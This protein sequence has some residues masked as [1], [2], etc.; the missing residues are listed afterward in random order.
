MRPFRC[1]KSAK[2]FPSPQKRTR[3]RSGASTTQFFYCAEYSQDKTRIGRKILGSLWRT[4]QP[5]VHHKGT[6][7]AYYYLRLS[8]GQE[9][10]L[11]FTHNFYPRLEQPCH[12]V[13]GK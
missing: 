12:A 6:S 9:A 11:P 7:T 8:M 1:Q 2:K 3:E 4:Q 10:F 13:P 5:R